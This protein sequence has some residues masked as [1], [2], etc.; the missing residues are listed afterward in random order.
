MSELELDFDSAQPEPQAP[1]KKA[2][3]AAPKK[4]TGKK[5]KSYGVFITWIIVLVVF[6]IFVVMCSVDGGLN[7]YNFTDAIRNAPEL[8]KLGDFFWLLQII[9]D[10]AAYLW[11]YI[12]TL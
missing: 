9:K 4:E 5:K 1:P 2:P 10:N 6:I 8:N 7:D 11:Q 12:K 3:K